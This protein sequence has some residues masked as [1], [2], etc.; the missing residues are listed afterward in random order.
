MSP[1]SAPPFADLPAA[2]AHATC[3]APGP[4]QASHDTSTSENV[5]WYVFAAASYPFT[6]FVEWHS[7]H[8]KFQFWYAP[9]QCSTS[10]C[11]TASFG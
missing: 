1:S 7:A 3:A 2:F 5:V 8:M 9:V 4:W 6:T 11:G 10:S